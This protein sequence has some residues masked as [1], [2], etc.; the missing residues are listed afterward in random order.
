MNWKH[1]FSSAPAA[2]AAGA[3]VLIW[4]AAGP[5]AAQ[6]TPDYIPPPP[7]QS[8]T[9]SATL[10]GKPS[11]QPICWVYKVAREGNGFRIFSTQTSGSIRGKAGKS[12]PVEAVPDKTARTDARKDQ[13]GFS[14]LLRK[15]ETVTL[16]NSP[17]DGCSAE[18]VAHGKRLAVEQK[19]WFHPH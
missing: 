8:E 19:L 9:R 13:P 18:V 16:S 6:A 17:H 15:G 11:D 1:P 3:M 12:R 4:L 7:M 14:F 10:Y 2:V 5:A